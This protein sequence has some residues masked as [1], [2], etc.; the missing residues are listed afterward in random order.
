MDKSWHEVARA[1]ASSQLALIPTDT[2][3]GLAAKALGKEAIG[4]LDKVKERADSKPYIILIAALSDLSVFNIYLSDQQKLFLNQIWPG[5]I[6]VILPCSSSSFA[7]LHR[8]RNLAF[9]LPNH[10]K[11]CSLVKMVGPLA[12]P[13]ANPAGE[14]PAKTIAMAKNYYGNKVAADIR[15]NQEPLTGIP[16]AVV[17]FS[18]PKPVLIRPSG[19]LV[20]KIIQSFTGE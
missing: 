15:A 10:S 20:E 17:D 14:S 13:S 6:S 5:P 2:I 19:P 9:R 12:A 8:G 4:R 3:Y 18:G 11:L 7:Y 16:S 1:L